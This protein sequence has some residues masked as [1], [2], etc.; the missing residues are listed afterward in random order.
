MN[1]E[2]EADE[3]EKQK[4]DLEQQVQELDDALQS[5][6]A[7]LEQANAEVERLSDILQKVEED[8]DVKAE[9]IESLAAELD[10]SIMRVQTAERRDQMLKERLNEAQLILT[11]KEAEIARLE[12]AYQTAVDDA[13][14]LAKDYDDL[15]AT[16]R[17]LKNKLT[18]SREQVEK[19]SDDLRA[20]ERLNQQQS[21]D[22]ARQIRERDEKY[23][24]MVESK[25]M[26]FKALEDRNEDLREELKEMREDLQ[27]MQSA[28]RDQAD[29]SQ[30]LGQS[31]VHDKYSLEL[32]IDRLKR[33]IAGMERELQASAAAIE[34]KEDL[35]KEKDAAG[36]RAT[37]EIR[38]LASK[39]AS[40]QQA[41]L[42]LSDRFDA[43][44]RTL[45]DAQLAA[46]EA[47]AKMEEMEQ[48]RNDDERNRSQVADHAVGQLKERNNLLLS[49]FQSLG[50]T[51]GAN[52]SRR[53][54]D[55]D[56]KPFTNFGVFHDSLLARLRRLGELQGHFEDRAKDME[57]KFTEQFSTI[58]KQ[59]DGQLRHI[60]RLEQTLK[61]AA[62]K[63][64]IWKSRIVAKQSELDVVKS[65]NAE[66]QQQ[67]AAL[68]TRS[69]LESPASNSKLTNLNSRANNAE[70]KLAL[71]QTHQSQA[72]ERLD[73]A[74][75]KYEEGENK[76]ASRIKE[77]EHRCR[78]AEEKNV[79]DR[80]SAKDRVK[81]LEE[82]LR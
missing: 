47:R 18:D 19:L 3:L 70:R 7:E 26:D 2:T 59:Q 29:Q 9:D 60:T 74:K 72:E 31:H 17:D 13:D 43:Q 16:H 21:E 8:R 22:F 71:A 48:Q 61:S 34:R 15:S 63:Q 24:A 68:R 45:R 56:L 66:L 67:V 25:D 64:S 77:L 30:R 10:E 37:S 79:R 39:L 75:R 35:L 54:G 23:K 12:E 46:D 11:E 52:K 51:L 33:Q 53:R 5:A 65:T 40:E 42:G 38:E 20:E 36:I 73:E 80:Q 76:W 44:S 57:S 50:R 4:I 55:D 81:E 41:R 6:E 49:I 62:D 14:Q 32:E 69:A 28:L 78:A 82:Q 58:K 27:K 1:V